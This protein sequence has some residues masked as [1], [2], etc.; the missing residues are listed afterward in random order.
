MLN[1]LLYLRFTSLVNWSWRRVKGLRHPTQ[2]LG[3]LAFA[4]YIWFFFFRNWGDPAPARSSRHLPAEML[5]VTEVVSAAV[6][7]HWLPAALAFAALALLVFVALIWIVPTQRA[8][9]GFSEAEIAFLFPAP[10]SRRALVHFRLLSGQARSLAGATVMMLISNRWSFLG[11]N[12]LT[13]ALGWWFVFSALNLHYSGANFTL[14]RLSDAGL[15]AIWRRVLALTFLL[16][17]IV[18][19]FGRLPAAARFPAWDDAAALRPLT[20]W[21]VA[22]TTTAPLSWV[23]WPFKLV[24]GPF[25]AA[26]ASAFY[27]AL[28]PAALVIGAHY[29]WVV[30]AAV[31]FEDAAIDH[32]QKRSA[33]LTAWRSG[34]SRFGRVP[35]L[36]R[37]APFRLGGTGRAEVAFLWKNLLSTWPYFNLRTLLVMAGIVTAGGMWMTAQPAWR[38]FQPVIGAGAAML[39]VYLLVIGPQ[40]ARQDI[41][42]DLLHADMLKTYPLPGWQIVLGELLTPAVILTGLLWLTLLAA[43]ITLQPAQLRA[44]WLTPA[45]RVTATLWLA[46]ITPALVTLQLLVPN[47][48]ALVFPA[49]FQIS[50]GRGGPEVA[51]LR[52]LFFF[53]Q[54]L[55]MVLAL[56]PA[57]AFAALL[58]FILHP[59]MGPAWA[60]NVGASAAVVIIAAEVWCGLWLLGER[61]DKYDISGDQRA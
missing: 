33:R 58:I 51:G 47:A 18:P 48:A 53:A 34:Q 41:R 42:S 3:L 35:T 4:C 46:V 1:A 28:G 52:M 7:A 61:F 25:L 21:I 16:A 43:A 44:E 2:L 56:L 55:T 57:A 26:D 36:G 39:G 15:G 23:L 9:L 30:K 13:H 54:L 24:L 31:A 38:G 10:V 45:L 59:F 32:A 17:A 19:T 37:A 12:P 6:P 40:F 11:G 22:L 60:L 49:W 14:T 29:L 50:R 8:A 27:F 20:D 5:D